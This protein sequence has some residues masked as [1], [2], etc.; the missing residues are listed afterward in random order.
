MLGSLS[1]LVKANL[2]LVYQMNMPTH[3]MHAYQYQSHDD[4]ALSLQACDDVVQDE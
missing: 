3:F 1:I 2:L 4:N